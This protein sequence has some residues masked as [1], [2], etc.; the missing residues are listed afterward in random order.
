MVFREVDPYPE[1]PGE[2]DL[3]LKEAASKIDALVGLPSE[4]REALRARASDFIEPRLVRLPKGAH[5]YGMQLGSK[6]WVIRNDHLDLV[7]A[8]GPTA[9]ALAAYST[10]T[11]PASS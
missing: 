9:V 5:P 11:T 8:A 10:A 2:R 7:T 4:V 6:R 3:R 1:S